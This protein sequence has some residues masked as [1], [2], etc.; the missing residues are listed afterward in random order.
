MEKRKKLKEYGA[1]YGFSGGVRGGVNRGGF[2]GGS[3]GA[4]QTMY[5]YE[6]KPLNHNLEPPLDDMDTQEIITP[7]KSIQ[8]FEMNKR[9]KKYHQ[10]TLLRIEKTP[11]GVIMYYVI[12]DPKTSTKMKLDPSS[13]TLVDKTAATDPLDIVVRKDLRS[14]MKDKMRVDK[15]GMIENT[16]V[17]ENIEDYL[18][19]S[20][21]ESLA[22]YCATCGKRAEH[23]EIEENP[24]M[25]CSNCGNR[26]WEQEH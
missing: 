8:G 13:V 5:V 24:N 7:G 11:E 12:L 15:V 1:G 22:Y 21:N 10:G 25:R 16:V 6:I 2:S 23:E 20:L 3:G 19:E 26:S 17:T 14:K 18:N 9:D 4:L